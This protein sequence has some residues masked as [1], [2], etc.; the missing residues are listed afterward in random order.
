MHRTAAALFLLLAPAITTAGTPAPATPLDPARVGWRELQ[1]G[2]SK[3]LLTADARLT[4]SLRP[5]GEIAG[6]L[7]G[8]PGLTGIPP[9]ESVVELLY[10]G[11]ATGRRTRAT[12]WLDP[13][14]G[15][16]LQ[17]SGDDLG[18][19]LRHRDYRFTTTG[20]Y[21]W[22]R[23][24][25][26]GEEKLP[27][28]RWTRTSEGLRAYGSDPGGPVLEPTGLIWA[29][30]AAPLLRPGDTA[31][32]AVFQRRVL[33]RVEVRVADTRRI[34]VDYRDVTPGGVTRRRGS[35]EAL[36]LVLQGDPDT[37][38]SS[39]ELELL[40]LR[41]AL[42]LHLDPVTRAP[43]SLSGNV[44]IVGAVT[45]RLQRLERFTPL[46]PARQSP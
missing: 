13:G 14:D 38:G 5:A 28:A 2:G 19:E 27:V 20:A 36:R 23:W 3:L 42:E 24:P 18:G 33:Q 46:A 25:A 4:W 45:L 32:F 8:A 22:T 16:A 7:R 12:L 6:Q 15:R 31:D 1:L 29:V 39:D 21:H 26:R 41:G 34:D 11:R 44:A 30:A 10:D 17:R 37:A 9:G 40:G 35:V 43:L